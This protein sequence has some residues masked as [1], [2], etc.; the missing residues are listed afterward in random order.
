MNIISREHIPLDTAQLR[1]LFDRL[2]LQ[3]HL[4]THN[5]YYNSPII[6]QRNNDNNNKNLPNNHNI[7]HTIQTIYPEYKW[8]LW[9]FTSLSREHYRQPRILRQLFDSIGEELSVKNLEDWY[10]ISPADVLDVLRQKS[11]L[12]ILTSDELN[13]NITNIDRDDI[14]SNEMNTPSTNPTADSESSTNNNNSNRKQF[15]LPQTITSLYPEYNWQHWKFKSAKPSSV[16]WTKTNQSDHVQYF[17]EIER[18][19]GIQSPQDWYSI[20]Y[21]IFKSS[22][23]TSAPLLAHCY[24]NSLVEL[25]RTMY[26]DYDWKLWKFKY[27]PTSYWEE[28]GP[29]EHRGIIE[30]LIE[31]EELLIKKPDDWYTVSYFPS[32]PF[33]FLS[34]SQY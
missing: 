26:P 16:Y 30:R 19:L 3:H 12:F 10:S 15:S 34:T 21:H 2:A 14:H 4:K 33:P 29:D 24:N 11:K 22:N 23:R 8:D 31:N 17:Q 7:L 9:K 28:M 27:L 32:F 1:Q 20:S 13:N 6:H 25:L 5:D 18:S